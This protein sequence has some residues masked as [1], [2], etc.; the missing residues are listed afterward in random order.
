MAFFDFFRSS[1]VS[2]TDLVWQNMEAKRKG[3]LDFLKNNKF[4]LC[5]AWFEETLDLF[6]H[7]LNE[8][9]GLNIEIVLGKSL[10]PY[11]L[12]KKTVL[13]LEHYPLFSKEQNILSSKSI[14]RVCFMNSLDDAVLKI[15]G[16]NISQMMKTMGMSENECLEHKLI[17]KSIIRAQK[18][19]EKIVH[20]DYPSK[21]GDEWMN[22]YENIKRKA[23]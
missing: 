7:F 23:F 11:S 1:E 19:L 3:C 10:F 15:F 21:S 18:K 16:G 9:N 6:K 20:R 12:E 13:F 4:D 2:R 14:Q 22:H 17:S 8:E 5:I